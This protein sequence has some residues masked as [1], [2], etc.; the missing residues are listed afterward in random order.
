MTSDRASIDT[1]RWKEDLVLAQRERCSSRAI[2]TTIQESPRTVDT[3]EIADTRRDQRDFAA[4][5][6]RPR[7]SSSVRF[8]GTA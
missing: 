5:T 2:A 7:R 8:S 6:I 3:R 1:T 4:C